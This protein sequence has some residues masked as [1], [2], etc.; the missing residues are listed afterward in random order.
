MDRRV[1]VSIDEP[2]SPLP[3]LAASGLSAYGRN[4]PI[5][6]ISGER[7]LTPLRTFAI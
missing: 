1:C 3:D 7:I 4:R 2:M 5:A 6:D